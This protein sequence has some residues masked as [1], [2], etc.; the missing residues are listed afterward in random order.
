MEAFRR[1]LPV[2][3]ARSEGTKRA[4]SLNVQLLRLQKDLRTGSISRD[5]VN[6]PSET[7]QVQRWHVYGSGT[8][9]AAC[10]RFASQKAQPLESLTAWP[11]KKRVPGPPNPWTND[12]QEMIVIRIWCSR[13]E[14]GTFMMWCAYV[15]L[16]LSLYIYIYTHMHTCII[17]VVH[18]YIYI[19]IY[20]HM[21]PLLLG[22]LL[23]IFCE[24]IHTNKHMYS[25]SKLIPIKLQ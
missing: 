23:V 2:C 15:S 20:T 25:L 13:C 1:V 3:I 17:Y 19:Y 14:P 6:F 12:V 24:Q 22:A 10:A 21:L 8:F 4:T 11:F 7:L 9:G 16:S 18:I 5:V